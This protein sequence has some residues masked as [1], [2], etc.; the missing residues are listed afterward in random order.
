V[1]QQVRERKAID[2]LPRVRPVQVNNSFFLSRVDA[3]ASSSR[4]LARSPRT[5]THRLPADHDAEQLD[6]AI[7]QEAHTRRVAVQLASGRHLHSQKEPA[8]HADGE[9]SA[10]Q[11]V[12]S[13]PTPTTPT[14]TAC[15]GSRA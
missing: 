12:G 13:S 2:S 10:S 3:A 4:T 14:P 1:G 6:G 9:K 7:S 11:P 15:V 5:R 8:V